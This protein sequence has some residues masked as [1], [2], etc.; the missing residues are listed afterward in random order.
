[1]KKQRGFTLIELMIVVAV[2]AILAAIAL[3]SYTNQTRKA[4]RAEAKQVLNDL[5]LRQEKWRHNNATYG[6]MTNLTGAATMTS[7]NGYYTVGAITYAPAVGNCAGGQA[8]GQA[9]SYVITATKAGDQAADAKCATF[10]VSNN[11]GTVTK[12]ST[13][14]ATDCW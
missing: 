11:C 1:M 7:P 13:G 6:T 4:R 9:N 3:T 8:I 5:I 14:T 2:V 10:V 12:S